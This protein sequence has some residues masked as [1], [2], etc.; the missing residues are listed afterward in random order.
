MGSLRRAKF[1][2]RIA[3]GCLKQKSQ[4]QVMLIWFATRCTDGATEVGKSSPEFANRNL[5]RLIG[6]FAMIIIVSAGLSCAGA[7]IRRRWTIKSAASS[8][9]IFGSVV[10]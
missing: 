9:D 5:D 8:T 1:D 2:A 6:L 7:F 10:L 4:K 3:T